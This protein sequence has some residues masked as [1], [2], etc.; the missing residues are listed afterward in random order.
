LGAT[1]VAPQWEAAK[2]FW[3]TG[4]ER[5]DNAFFNQLINKQPEFVAREVPE[6]SVS[7]I[8]NLKKILFGYGTP[9]ERL[10]ARRVWSNFQRSFA[11]QHIFMDQP[12]ETNFTMDMLGGMKQRLNDHGKDQLEAIYDDPAGKEFLENMRAFAQLM[13]SAKFRQ[14]LEVGGWKSIFD[15]VSIAGLGAGHA[16]YQGISGY[17]AT[18][19]I[20]GVPAS[21]ALILRSR[22]ATK[23]FLRMAAFPGWDRLPQASKTAIGARV[24][25]EIVK[26]LKRSAPETYGRGTLLGEPLEQPQGGGPQ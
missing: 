1:P 15:F 3:K 20:Q 8:Q 13:S 9:R 18:A 21:L 19:L 16:Q 22:P 12:Q 14:G 4:R 25:A 24:V 26:S 23:I 5:F 10:Q 6:K 7:D 17:G 11:E 2:T